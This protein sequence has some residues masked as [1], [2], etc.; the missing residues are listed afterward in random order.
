MSSSELIGVPTDLPVN[1]SG[2]AQAAPSNPTAST[3]PVCLRVQLLSGNRIHAGIGRT[4]RSLTSRGGGFEPW[5]QTEFQVNL[6]LGL[7]TRSPI[8]TSRQ[9]TVA[10]KFLPLLIGRP[11]GSVSSDPLTCNCSNL[12]NFCLPLGTRMTLSPEEL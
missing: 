10:L 8:A 12:G 4:F 11:R 9:P 7:T 5:S 1:Q 6:K 3:E 2:R